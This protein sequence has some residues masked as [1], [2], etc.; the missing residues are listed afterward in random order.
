MSC[1][2][3]LIG[4]ARIHADHTEAGKLPKVFVRQPGHDARMASRRAVASSPGI[5]LLAAVAACR[6][7]LGEPPVRDALGAEVPADMAS[8]TPASPECGGQGNDQ[9][10]R[11]KF[12]PD[13]PEALRALVT[14]DAKLE[15]FLRAEST[16]DA[17]CIAGYWRRLGDERAWSALRSLF[18]AANRDQVLDLARFWAVTRVALNKPSPPVP[19][20]SSVGSG[21]RGPAPLP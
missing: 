4:A 2:Y 18:G 3:A 16:N 7:T 17:E 10:A 6:W 5:L 11:A 21:R 15:L 20:P 19:P 13:V 12:D 8:V 14:P 9:Q 1:R